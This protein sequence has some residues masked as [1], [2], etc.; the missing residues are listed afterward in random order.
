MALFPSSDK[1]Q[2][3]LWFK[4][5]Y[6]R[7]TFCSNTSSNTHQFQ[8]KTYNPIPKG[9]KRHN[10]DANHTSKLH[11]YKKCSPETSVVQQTQHECFGTLTASAI[12]C[13]PNVCVPKRHLPD[14]EAGFLHFGNR[15]AGEVYPQP[16]LNREY[17]HSRSPAITILK[18]M[19]K[20]SPAQLRVQKNTR[21]EMCTMQCDYG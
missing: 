3:V 8:T 11:T 13:V 15:L 21:S 5:H 16:S 1:N 7:N 9:G 20:I 19:T 18:K 2:V 12:V 6:E 4:H 17:N 10:Q 14:S